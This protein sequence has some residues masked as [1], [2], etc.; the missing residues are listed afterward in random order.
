MTDAQWRLVE[1]AAAARETYASTFVREAAVNAA[2]RELAE[3]D[4]PRD[5]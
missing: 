2:R 3:A 4:D 5:R 1:A